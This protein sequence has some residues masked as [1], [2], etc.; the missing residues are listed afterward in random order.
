[1]EPI[2]CGKPPRTRSRSV[3]ALKLLGR[4]ELGAMLREDGQ[5]EVTC[6]FCNMVY[7]V[8]ADELLELIR[9]LEPV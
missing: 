4:D 6:H 9:E 1:M 7:R 8:E 2:G 3:G 5:A